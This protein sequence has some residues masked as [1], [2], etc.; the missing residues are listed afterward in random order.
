MRRNV[1]ADARPH[2]FPNNSGNLAILL[3]IRRASSVLRV[4]F[5]VFV[6]DYLRRSG[7][8]VQI[9]KAAI[10]TDPAAAKTLN[11]IISYHCE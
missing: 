4:A 1:R 10:T 11:A 8:R 3:A 2:V 9:A 5:P 7:P 6:R